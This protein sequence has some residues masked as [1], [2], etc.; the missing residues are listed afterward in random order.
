MTKVFI[1][2]GK[3]AS[4]KSS[5]ANRL[6]KELRITVFCKDDILEPIKVCEAIDDRGLRNEVCYRVLERLVQRSVDNGADIILD[7]GLGDRGLAEYFI[8]QIDFKDS[9]V[10]SFFVEC[11]NMDEWKRRHEE[12]IAN[13]L[14]SQSFKSFDHVLSHYENF[15]GRL[16]K[17][18]YEIDSSRSVSESFTELLRIL[19]DK[20]R[21]IAMT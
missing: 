1:F 8:N 20:P 18:E 21:T 14:P 13:P 12:R 5:L 4:G 6:A 11:K 9:E 2:R 19:N 10:I 16:F 17:N 15:D 3:A 7:I